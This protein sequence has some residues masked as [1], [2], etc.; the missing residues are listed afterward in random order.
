V[1]AAVTATPD[2]AKMFAEV[3]RLA[4]AKPENI[5][6]RLAGLPDPV[7]QTALLGTEIMLAA[8]AGCGKTL[9]RPHDEQ[10]HPLK[11]LRFIIGPSVKASP[12]MSFSAAC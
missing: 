5:L 6:E 3:I 7:G 11:T 1:G 12:Q 10:K 8:L 2:D 4:V 9:F